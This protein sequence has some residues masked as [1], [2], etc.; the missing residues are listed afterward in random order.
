MLEHVRQKFLRCLQ[1]SMKT[2]PWTLATL[3][4]LFHAQTPN[5][6]SPALNL[7]AIS[8]SNGESVI[9]CWALKSEPASFAAASNFYL[10]GV[11]NGT[12]S[13]IPPRTV[14]GLH[15]APYVQ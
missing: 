12:Y 3:I 6:P 1:P 2:A 7:T 4:Q 13:V 11:S 8:A 14:V 10:G 15:H 5:T 9:E